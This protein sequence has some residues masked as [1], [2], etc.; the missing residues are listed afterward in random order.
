MTNTNQN[1]LLRH[2]AFCVSP[3]SGQTYFF[4]RICV[5]LRQFGRAYQPLSVRFPP[6]EREAAA[7]GGQRVVQLSQQRGNNSNER[8]GKKKKKTRDLGLDS[9]TCVDL[10]LRRMDSFLPLP[11]PCLFCTL[12][13]HPR[14]RTPGLQHG[15]MPDTNHPTPTPNP[16][17]K[18]FQSDGSLSGPKVDLVRPARRNPLS[19]RLA[20]GLEG[21]AGFTTAPANKSAPFPFL[22]RSARAR[23]CRGEA[24]GR[25]PT[26]CADRWEIPPVGIDQVSV[27]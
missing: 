6:T 13:R 7:E 17:P 27:K 20:K 1:L 11:L 26:T 10:T 2:L 15:C 4:L 12:P 9:P 8:A 5:L 3:P 18:P 19:G 14:K 23:K 24:A 16:S 21:S 25:R 22:A